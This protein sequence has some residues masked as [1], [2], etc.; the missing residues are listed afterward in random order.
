M[1]AS[2]HLI[3]VSQMLEKANKNLRTKGEGGLA[4][5]GA[6]SVCSTE[7]KIE[8]PAEV[9]QELLVPRGTIGAISNKRREPVREFR[10]P[11]LNPPMVLRHKRKL[12]QQ[13]QQFVIM[14]VKDE[15]E[16]C[17]GKI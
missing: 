10:R 9:I 7:R 17:A 3:N 15:E 11:T 2:A 4:L 6:N 16:K 14:N 12:A 5:G 8:N 13:N 1:R